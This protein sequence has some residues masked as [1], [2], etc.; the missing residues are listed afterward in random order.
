MDAEPDP[1]SNLQ[2]KVSTEI[3]QA[4]QRTPVSLE[5]IVEGAEGPTDVPP[6]QM[7]EALQKVLFIMLH[8]LPTIAG[9]VDL[10]R[11]ELRRLSERLD[12]LESRLDEAE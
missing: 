1:F 5:A 8:Q 12:A 4:F 2:Q 11:G 9:A 3:F 10:T 7:A 6:E